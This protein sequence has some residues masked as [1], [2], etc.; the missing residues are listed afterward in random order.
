MLWAISSHLYL[1][2]YDKVGNHRGI[3]CGDCYWALYD[4]HWC[5]NPDCIYYRKS[6]KTIIYLSNEEAAILLKEKLQNTEK[7]L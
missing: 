4:G 2:V 3:R 6:T 1:T 7:L 5:Q